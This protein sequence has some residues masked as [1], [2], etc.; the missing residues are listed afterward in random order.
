M[1]RTVGNHLLAA[2]L[3]TCMPLARLPLTAQ[4][5]QARLLWCCEIVDWRVEW[6]SAVFSDESR[7]CLYVSDGHTHVWHRLGEHH[8]PECICPRHAGPT[9]GFLVWG[10]ISYNPQSHLVY[11]EGK[12]NSARYIAQVVNPV[13]LPFLR[14]EGDVHVHI[15]LL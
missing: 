6:H 3:R 5:H 10:A 15:R 7:F 4:H 13:L 2:G 9:S 11:L 14:L 12:V 1:P 8:L